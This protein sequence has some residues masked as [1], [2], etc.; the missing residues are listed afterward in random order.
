MRTAVT[1]HKKILEL[2]ERRIERAKPK[3]LEAMNKRL[4][5]TDV[6]DTGPG[7][8]SELLEKDEE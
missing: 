5:E 8:L 6:G 4:W 3:A 7:G 1:T 2:L